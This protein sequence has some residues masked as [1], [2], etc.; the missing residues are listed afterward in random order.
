MSG[1]DIIAIA[2]WA[3]TFMLLL[4]YAL[5]SNGRIPGDGRTYQLMNIAGSAGL[6]AAAFTGR[7]WSSVAFNGIWVV[8]GF[9]ALERLRR[10]RA[11][12]RSTHIQTS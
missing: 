5:V 11:R 7:V 6:G 3:G 2:G 1:H 12:A 9:V 8:L 10:R 4:G